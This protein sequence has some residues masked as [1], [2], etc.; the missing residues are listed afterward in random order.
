MRI[1]N[2]FTKKAYPWIPLI[3]I[4]LI[5]IDV[6]RDSTDA[7]LLVSDLGFNNKPAYYGSMAFQIVTAIIIIIIISFS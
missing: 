6:I 5:L 2:I 7:N 4:L 3:G 1:R